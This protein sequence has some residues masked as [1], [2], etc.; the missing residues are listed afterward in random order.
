MANRKLRF[1][2]HIP[3]HE[4]Q[5]YYSGS[6]REVVTVSHDGRTLKFPANRLRSVV[7]RDGINGE[8]EIEFD[9]QNRFVALRKIAD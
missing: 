4:Y 6:A 1:F 7:G 5:L 8:F 2:L 9:E 3:A